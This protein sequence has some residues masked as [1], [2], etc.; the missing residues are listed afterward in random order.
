[1]T[2]TQNIAAIL[3]SRPVRHSRGMISIEF[4]LSYQF[5]DIGKFH[6]VTN[7]LNEIDLNS[8]SVQRAILIK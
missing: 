4:H 3:S 1:M 2:P 7:M 5:I 6:V 8:L